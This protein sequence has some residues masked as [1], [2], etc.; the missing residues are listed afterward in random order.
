MSDPVRLVLSGDLSSKWQDIARSLGADNVAVIS[1]NGP[2]PELLTH[3]RRLAPCVLITPESLFDQVNAETFSEAIDFG[4][5]IRVLVEY[6][7]EDPLRAERLIRMG[8]V[9]L[10]SREIPAEQ[11]LRAIT[12]VLDGELWLSRKTSSQALQ[13]LIREARYHLT[14]RES[15][16]LSLLGE[17]LKN[18]EIAERLFISPQT[19]RWHLRS[20]YSKLGTHDRNTAA[21][22]SPAS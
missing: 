18:H 5:S 19:V 12:A 17:G 6:R 13:K 2:P 7:Q 14:S 4:R 20:L 1:Y 10:L 22:V 9:G 16:I 11:A 15:Q 3:C 8:C 21:S